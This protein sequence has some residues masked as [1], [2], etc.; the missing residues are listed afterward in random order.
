M[1]KDEGCNDPRVIIL[2]AR[3]SIFVIDPAAPSGRCC[4]GTEAVITA[5]HHVGDMES[6]EVQDDPEVG[7][8]IKTILKAFDGHP[9]KLSFL[10]S[11]NSAP[12]LIRT[13]RMLL[14]VI[15]CDAYPLPHDIPKIPPRHFMPFQLSTP[16]DG[17]FF[18]SF[19]C[20]TDRF[21]GKIEP[22]INSLHSLC[23][24]EVDG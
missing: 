3:G 12:G 20:Q 19:L 14:T 10:T 18:Q 8:R 24:F 15:G 6:L 4:G 1:V 7:T 17:G 22:A 11:L 13:I 9:E 2:N 5:V 23:V 16:P 21:C